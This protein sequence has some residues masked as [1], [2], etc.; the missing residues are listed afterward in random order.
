MRML[1]CDGPGRQFCLEC[2]DLKYP[3]VVGMFGEVLERIEASGSGVGV[4]GLRV[5]GGEVWSGLQKDT[6]GKVKHYGCVCWSEVALSDEVIARV[7]EAGRAGIPIEQWTPVRVLHR[8]SD[9]MRERVV[10]RVKVER[11]NGH[12]FKCW[13]ST[14]AGTYVKEFV[15][16]DGGRTTPSLAG[17]IGGKCDILQLDCT[18]IEMD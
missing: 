1:D 3:L 8:R 4:E 10:H 5:C 14:Q 9:L 12:W 17:M 2:I 16:G 15:T 6:E 7:E 13:V 18:G 11:I